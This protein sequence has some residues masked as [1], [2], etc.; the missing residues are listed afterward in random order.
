MDFLCAMHELD[1]C[2]QLCGTPEQ[3]ARVARC[4]TVELDHA[5]SELS[6]STAA[7]VTIRNGKVTLV[8]R[9]MR[10]EYE[11][12]INTAQRVKNHREKQNLKQESNGKVTPY[13]SSSSSNTNNGGGGNSYAPA[14]NAPPTA[15][16]LTDNSQ[17]RQWSELTDEEKLLSLPDFLTHLQRLHPKKNVRRIAE[18]LQK[19]CQDFGKD[20]S[21]ERLK[22]WVE[23]EHNTV[24]EAEFLAA[25]GASGTADSA[26]A[27]RKAIENCQLCDA[28]GYIRVGDSVKVCRHRE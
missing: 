19:F 7:D 2:G 15:A 17:N 1:R 9:R 12:R 18:K 27:R 11:T 13:S 21:L 23:G 26:E 25:F 4:S 22:G 8:N 14:R 3:L 20:F 24:S 6:A 28:H 16:D 5:L 10:R